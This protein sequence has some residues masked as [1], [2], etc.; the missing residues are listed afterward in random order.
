MSGF[1]QRW[2]KRVGERLSIVASRMRARRRAGSAAIE[3]AFVAPVFFIF[4]LGTIETGVMFLGDFMLQNATA[5]A[6]REIRT[7]QVVLKVMTKDQFRGLLCG[8]IGLLLT[9][10][11]RL[12]ID[13]R[14]YPDFG[15]MTLPNPIQPDGTLDPNLNNWQPGNACSIVLVRTF[16]TWDVITPLLAPL[17]RNFGDNKHLLSSAAAFRNEPYTTQVSGC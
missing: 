2:L 15:S 4:M 3:F 8:K 6:A 11:A 5:D 17:L 14:T 1:A 9:C 7:G 10:D 13:V 16:Y 12:L